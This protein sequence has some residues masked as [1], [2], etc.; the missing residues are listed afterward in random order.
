MA[1]CG[2]CVS[3]QPT[4]PCALCVLALLCGLCRSLVSL[5]VV[6]WHPCGGAVSPARLGGLRLLV[7]ADFASSHWSCGRCK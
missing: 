1:Q 6:D 4:L 3:S 5:A 2:V 7:L